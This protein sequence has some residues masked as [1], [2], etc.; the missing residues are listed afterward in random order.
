MVSNIYQQFRNLKHHGEALAWNLPGSGG[1]P[2]PSL[3]EHYQGVVRYPGEGDPIFYVSQ[4]QDGV[5][6][7]V[8]GAVTAG[9]YLHV[10]RFGS[11]DTDGERL[12]SNLQV[13]G[14]HTGKTTPPSS[15]RWLSSFK[16]NYS[17][18]IK[19]EPLGSIYKHPGGMAI[20]DNI[21]FLSVDSKV[22]GPGERGQIILFD[23]TEDP[24]NPKPI[25][26]LPLDHDIDNLAITKLEDGTYLIYTNG[27]GG[28]ATKLYKTNIHEGEVVDL[29]NQHLELIFLGEPDLTDASWNTGGGAHQS[30]T[31]IREPDG[32]LYLIG[33]RH[34]GVGRVGSDYADLLRVEPK[35]DGEYKFVYLTTRHL[36]CVYQMV[37]GLTNSDKRICNFAAG[38]NAYVS[39]TGE[40]ILYSVPHDD[41][42]NVLAEERVYLGEFRHKEVYRPTNPLRALTVRANS[43]YPYQLTAD[44]TVQL[45]G[46]GWPAEARPWVELF[47]DAGFADRSI[48][49]DYDDRDLLELHNFDKLDGF[50]DKTSSIRWNMPVGLDLEL[51]DDHG[52][53][54]R[55]I[56]IRGTGLVEEV[57]DLEF[58]VVEPGTIEHPGRTAGQRVEFNDKTSSVRFVGTPDGS[59]L[60]LNWDLD[61][62]GIFG[63]TGLDAQNGDERGATPTFSANGLDGPRQHLIQ[64]EVTGMAPFPA[65]DSTYVS[66]PNVAPTAHAGDDIVIWEGSTVQLDGRQS[67]DPEINDTLTYEWDLDY[68]GD[69]FEVDATGAEPTFLAENGPATRTA[70]L[71]VTDDDGGISEIDTVEIEILNKA[72]ETSIDSVNGGVEGIAVTNVPVQL[73][74]RF[75]DVAADTH[76]AVIDWGD[77]NVTSS[78]INQNDD[79]LSRLHT[80]AAPGTHQINLNITD[81]DGGS[82]NSYA[83]II[84]YDEISAL[85][86]VISNILSILPT[87]QPAAAETALQDA[88]AYL[89]RS[90]LR[91][92][93]PGALEE[94]EAGNDVAALQQ[95]EAA[96]V[97]L[98]AAEA[99][100]GA[101]F[102]SEKQ[103][104]VLTAQGVARR[105]IEAAMS[106][107]GTR[108]TP[109]EQQALAQ[110]RGLHTDGIT[111][112]ENGDYVTA[113]QTF[114]L[115]TSIAVALLP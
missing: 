77:G 27:A 70:A 107:L 25:K 75:T 18:E 101:D 36:Y 102:A 30:S 39:P 100:S 83:T 58:Q 90:G 48:V 22:E 91:T 19:D 40:L 55:K 104:L 67:F 73:N 74:G 11:R 68:D 82:D 26:A 3:F 93:T 14:E 1:A 29:R 32:T 66:I 114:T 35:S 24:A 52:F 108:P 50:T 45:A 38:N 42:D 92:G 60:E 43:G 65:V 106:T 7:F 110:S 47:D 80:Y 34:E 16:F 71:R 53:E 4:R 87:I 96:I 17:F 21:L 112:F 15:D 103:L 109:E 63:E 76:T 44:G 115:S 78:N 28:E 10:F 61:G 37:G 94:F 41:D 98:E 12:R 97:A 79:T 84:V 113:V 31:F 95:V 72:P 64:L 62:D 111:Y 99:Y 8:N 6:G 85:E 56:V 88:R 105:N 89:D 57:R 33:M 86:A 51:F 23:L 49:I 9:G 69:S 5:V 46:A 54:D 20:M 81:N 59:D 13:N 2:D